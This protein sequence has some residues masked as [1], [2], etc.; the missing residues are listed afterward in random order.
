VQD[1]LRSLYSHKI[2]K[3]QREQVSFK[4]RFESW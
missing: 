1:A 4:F 2:R 3:G